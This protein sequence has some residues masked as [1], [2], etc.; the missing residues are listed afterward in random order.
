MKETIPFTELSDGL[1]LTL[2]GGIEP[3][4]PEAVNIYLEEDFI[5]YEPSEE[6]NLKKQPTFYELGKMLNNVGALLSYV[7]ERLDGAQLQAFED[8]L[9]MFKDMMK[10]FKKL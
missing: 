7:S 8:K 3:I 10:N 6:T 1:Q 9:Q 4:T 2:P 5:N